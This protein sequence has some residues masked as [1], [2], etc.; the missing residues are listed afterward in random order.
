VTPP[1]GSAKA[2]L[3]HLVLPVNCLALCV[4]V[5]ILVRNERAYAGMELGLHELVARSGHWA[6]VW[7]GLSC[8]TIA[9]VLAGMIGARRVSTIMAIAA[10]VGILGV[11]SQALMERIELGRMVV[12][13]NSARETGLAILRGPRGP[14]GEVPDAMP[15]Q[16][17]ARVPLDGWG[18]PLLYFKLSPRK[19]IIVAPG[20]DGMVDG[21][22]ECLDREEWFPPSHFWHDI[23]VQ[24]GPDVVRTVPPEIKV[25]MVPAVP[26][27][28][29][30]PCD[31][32]SA[33]GCVKFWG[34]QRYLRYQ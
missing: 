26:S 3:S 5:W 31:V 1:R 6:Q 8:V 32:Y 13:I 4:M 11:E 34:Y 22:P 7:V 24:I 28:G 12:S 29:E 20:A 33:F 23:V 18:H 25:A 21:P 16:I 30:L 14:G 17:A 2:L 27:T 10:V 9:G 15:E 19:A